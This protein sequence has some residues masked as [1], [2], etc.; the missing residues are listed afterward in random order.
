VSTVTLQISAGNRIEYVEMPGV[1]AMW[2]AAMRV[3]EQVG[4]FEEDGSK[5]FTLTPTPSINCIP[6]N[7]IAAE[8][9]GQVLY[10]MVWDSE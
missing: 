9:D 8:W 1:T 6:D 4:I 7:D 10:L 2:S 3:A 5:R